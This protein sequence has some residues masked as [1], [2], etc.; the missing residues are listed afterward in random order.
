MITEKEAKKKAKEAKAT[1]KKEKEDK[2]QQAKEK[3]NE[4]DTEEARLKELKTM[5]R[6]T[7]SS[8][9]K[10]VLQK[11]GLEN[12]KKYACIYFNE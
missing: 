7:V 4:K 11:S 6:F 10:T 3:R 1:K 2:K 9:W 5:Q 8:A 12:K